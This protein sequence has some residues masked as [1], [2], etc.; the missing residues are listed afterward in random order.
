MSQTAHR[1]G[2]YTRLSRDTEGTQTSTARQATDC[3]HLAA[4]KEW[5]VADVYEDV[6][7]SA[8]KRNVR[9]PAYERMLEDLSSSLID[10]VVVWKL[11]RLVRRAGEF[12]RF[13]TICEERGATLAAVHDPIDT[14]TEI[15]M[16]IV[17]VLVA[18][19]QLEAGTTSLRIKA[20]I[21]DRARSGKPTA[22]GGRRPFGF[23]ADKL[24]VREEEAELIRQAASRILAGESLHGLTRDWN[25][26]G[27]KTTIGGPWR[28]TTLR[29]MLITPRVAGL[30]EHRGDIAGPGAW[31]PILDLDT[32]EKLRSAIARRSGDQ[33]EAWGSR[34]NLLVGLLTCGKCGAKMRAL[35][36]WEGNG[37]RKP[38][39][40]NYVC[41]PTTQGGCG[42]IAVV[43][44]P[45]DAVVEEAIYGA[46]DSPEFTRFLSATVQDSR[47]ADVIRLLREDEAA[48]EQLTHDH[49][50]ERIIDRRSFLSA[51]E[52]LEHRI[53]KARRELGHN[54]RTAILTGLPS[55]AAAL[56][57]AWEEGGIDW[58]HSVLESLIERVTVHPTLRGTRFNPN[59][60]EIR[61]RF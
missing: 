1:V 52:T 18:F 17:R 56:Q 2:V 60:I 45:V 40:R 3:K 9:R 13:W 7:L 29:R 46:V 27:I 57:K 51:K 31:E 61:W 34:R 23:E 49:Y 14:S 35:S 22:Y 36:A 53:E 24:T 28:Q 33:K 5:T 21:A 44:D 54:H 38:R 30:V 47:E 19:A 48:L 4:S 58:R 16:V 59:R 55:G 43:A 50:A 8:Y 26:A 20:Q 41:P 10:G 6:D 11:D 37:T 15:G 42:G 25:A 32:W 12:E 39:P